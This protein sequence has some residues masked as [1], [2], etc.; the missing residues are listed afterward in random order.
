MVF[1]PPLIC[2]IHDSN[3]RWTVLLHIDVLSDWDGAED[4]MGDLDRLPRGVGR[5]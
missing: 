1:L 3:F 5:E 4:F 2:D